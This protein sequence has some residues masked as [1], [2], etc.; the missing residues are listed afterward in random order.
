M[1]ERFLYKSQIS[2]LTTEL[3]GPIRMC[4]DVAQALSEIERKLLESPNLR[5]VYDQLS[6]TNPPE[7]PRPPYEAISLGDMEKLFR[8]DDE[9][10]A[11]VATARKMYLEELGA[12]R[13]KLHGDRLLRETFINSVRISDNAVAFQDALNALKRLSAL[14][15]LTVAPFP[16]LTK[17]AEEWAELVR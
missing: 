16:A 3:M 4:L 8:R 12:M 11:L 6:L 2:L 17:E 9:F 1:L 10:A 5:A 7:S 15:K 13:R 14:S